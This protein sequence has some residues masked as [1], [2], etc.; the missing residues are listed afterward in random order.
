ML[1]KTYFIVKIIVDSVVAIFRAVCCI[2]LVVFCV[3]RLLVEASSFQHLLWS[4]VEE[5]YLRSRQIAPLVFLLTMATEDVDFEWCSQV[6]NSVFIVDIFEFR[7]DDLIQGQLT[8]YMMILLETKDLLWRENRVLASF[9]FPIKFEQ[10]E[11]WSL[12]LW[13]IYLK[14]HR[15]LDLWVCSSYVRGSKFKFRNFFISFKLNL[16]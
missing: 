11:R 1:E 7:W 9:W 14:D 4:R 16:G 2:W 6:I 12:V 3:D 5:D 15:L 8:N 10:V 13:S